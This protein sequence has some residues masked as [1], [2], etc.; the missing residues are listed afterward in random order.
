MSG[1]AEEVQQARRAPAAPQAA[2]T[3]EAAAPATPAA[4]AADPFLPVG[5]VS[6]DP[7]A[8]AAAAAAKPAEPAKPAS[9]DAPKIRIAGQ[10]FSSLEDAIRYA[11]EIAIAQK[12]DKAFREGVEATKEKPAPAAPEPTFIDKAK[13]LIFEDP[14]KAIDLIVEG[15]EQRI[16]DTYNKMTAEQQTQAAQKAVYDATWNDFYDKNPDLSASRD[17]VMYALEKNKATLY[18]QKTPEALASL[19]ALVRK[20][21]RIQREES[22]PS[23]ELPNKPAMG[24]G[25]SSQATPAA[26]PATDA[27][28]LDF[29]QQM[30][31]LRK[32]K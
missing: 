32:R 21:L 16:F 22:L 24:P 5:A 9:A 2:P 17:Y 20:D 26:A 11:D 18:A 25:A 31:R 12:E 13:K 3:P 4:A 8:D 6:L 1:F 29:V 30:S 19:A 15:T 23:M 27:E 14:D 10:E 28:P 7:K